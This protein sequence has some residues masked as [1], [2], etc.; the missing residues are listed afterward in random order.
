MSVRRCTCRSNVGN[1]LI[2]DDVS[3]SF[4]SRPNCIC[5]GANFITALENLRRITCI[6]VYIYCQ[7]SKRKR[8]PHYFYNYTNTTLTRTIF[9]N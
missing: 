2:L 4:T 7:A 1:S 8:Q 3:G 5:N 6:Y 9:L